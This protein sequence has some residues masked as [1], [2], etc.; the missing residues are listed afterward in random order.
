MSIATRIAV[1]LAA[2]A[3]VGCQSTTVATSDCWEAGTMLDVSDAAGAGAGY[4]DPDLW[5]G[6]TDDDLVIEGNGI[7]TYQFV[8]MTPNALTEQDYS[9]TI[10][11]APALAAAPTDIPLLGL[12]GVAVNGLVFFGP[13][14]AGVPNNTAWG[15]P[16]HNG[17]TDGCFGHTAGEYHQHALNP[18]CLT[19]DAVSESQ[20]WTLSDPD[21]TTPSPIIGWA[22]D[23]F[24]VYGPHGCVD[25][26][27][28]EV[29]EMKSGYDPIGD[30]TTDA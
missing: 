13:N 14:E 18:K 11:R 16:I 26:A 9:F 19:Q 23:G 21:P 22:M 30:P 20:P 24:P 5:A 28:S 12:V 29:A 25:A 10:P 2:V 7:P 15:D 4:A 8:Q 6:C 1:T 17:I 3:F 27:C